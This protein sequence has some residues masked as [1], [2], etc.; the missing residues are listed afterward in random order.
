MIRSEIELCITELELDIVHLL[1]T[2]S[3]NSAV[4]SGALVLLEVETELKPL[5]IV[6]LRIQYYNDIARGRYGEIGFI[7]DTWVQTNRNAEEFP[8]PRQLKSNRE[9]LLTELRRL[10]VVDWLRQASVPLTR[11]DRLWQFWWQMWN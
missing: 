4:S 5:R 2:D 3:W 7:D 9:W 8:A 10:N 6:Y 1:P 11:Y